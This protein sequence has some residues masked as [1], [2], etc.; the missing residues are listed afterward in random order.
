MAWV[1]LSM[2]LARFSNVYE[3]SLAVGRVG[4][5]EARKVGRDYVVTV[6]QRRN[7]VAVHVRRCRETM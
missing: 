7:K 2:T 6:G 4:K 5:T 3:E 1:K